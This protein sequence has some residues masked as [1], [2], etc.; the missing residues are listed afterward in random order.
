[1]R[2][3]LVAVVASLVTSLIV[4]GATIA[5]ANHQWGDVPT[6]NAFHEDIDAFTEA[7]CGQGY[8]NSQFR[9][10]EPVL[11]QQ[12]ARFFRACGTRIAQEDDDD[13]TDVPTNPGVT[14]NS[15]GITAGAQG[16][17]GGFVLALATITL[18][19]SDDDTA[20]F[21]CTVALS[22]TSPTAGHSGLA[23]LETSVGSFRN[24]STA[25]TQVQE[26]TLTEVWEVA[27]GET[28]TG[29]TTA[30]RF[31]CDAEVDAEGDLTLLYVPFAGNA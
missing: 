6:G 12:A 30:T 2:T 22:L 5:Y 29:R 1:M 15:E 18:S 17:G 9:P 8:P 10:T 28:I 23:N 14:L 20:D 11:R 24:A 7:G 31:G 21:P 19:T 16:A 13:L 25:A 27:A 4:G 3:T 26:V